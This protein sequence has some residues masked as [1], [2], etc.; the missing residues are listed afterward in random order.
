LVK[1]KQTKWLTPNPSDDKSISNFA[2][3]SEETFTVGER[4][5]PVYIPGASRLDG[6]Q[7]DEILHDQAEKTDAESKNTVPYSPSTKADRQKLAEVNRDYKS[8]QSARERRGTK[9]K[10][11]GGF[12]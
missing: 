1:K 2:K 7:L 12:G 9:R 10:F 4:G 8:W 5:Q 6:S 11:Y 3:P